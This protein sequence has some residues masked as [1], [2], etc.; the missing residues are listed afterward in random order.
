MIGATTHYVTTDLD[1]G[2]IIHQDVE[3]ITHK[4][5]PDDLV[6]KGRDVERRVLAEGV[7]L[8]LQD[9]TFMVGKKTVVLK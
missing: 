1:E 6:R 9:R 2:P 4:D 3:T 8:H 5:Q 7:R